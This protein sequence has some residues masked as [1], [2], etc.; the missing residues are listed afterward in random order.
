MTKEQQVGYSEP[1]GGFKATPSH[2]SRVGK[3]ASKEV[4]VLLLGL[5]LP[6]PCPPPDAEGGLK[7]T[8][9]STRF[10]VSA[11]RTR[12]SSRE[13]ATSSKQTASRERT[14]NGSSIPLR[15]PWPST[16]PGTSAISSL[17]PRD[18]HTRRRPLR[19]NWP[20]PTHSSARGI[21]S[22]AGSISIGRT[23]RRP[24]HPS[25]WSKSAAVAS[26]STSITMRRVAQEGVASGEGEAGWREA[27]LL[28]EGSSDSN[29]PQ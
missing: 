16:C 14:E 11:H 5:T 18:R 15:G 2:A 28:N 23:R 12:H 6:R 1:A 3:A 4:T 22:S 26:I 17:G 25:T 9:C 27:R 21:S 24:C 10:R 29:Q 20:P 8:A 7:G 19:S 13:S